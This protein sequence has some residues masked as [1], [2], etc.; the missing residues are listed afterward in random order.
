MLFN[1][2]QD[3]SQPSSADSFSQSKIFMNTEKRFLRDKCDKQNS[4]VSICCRLVQLPPGRFRSSCSGF[5][6][7]VVPR[8]ARTTSKSCCWSWS[9]HW[10]LRGKCSRNHNHHPWAPTCLIHN[11]DVENDHC[12]IWIVAF[13]NEGSIYL[14]VSFNVCRGSGI[15]RK[16]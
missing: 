13:L 3:I 5:N 15:A 16:W 9:I 2:S 10:R 8:V 14:F 1:N 7:D 12:S 6:Y 4:L 11:T